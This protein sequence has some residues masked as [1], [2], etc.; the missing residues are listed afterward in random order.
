MIFL[1]KYKKFLYN[2]DDDYYE[3]TININHLSVSFTKNFSRIITRYITND[4]ILKIYI[5]K[6]IEERIPEDERIPVSETIVIWYYVNQDCDISFKVELDNN[7]IYESLHIH[8]QKIQNGYYPDIKTLLKKCV[9][10][11]KYSDRCLPKRGCL[12]I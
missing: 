1:K 12:I 3:K 6:E 8:V 11:K 4:E 5:I 2:W 7:K 9:N 10:Y